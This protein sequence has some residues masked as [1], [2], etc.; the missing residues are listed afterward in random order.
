VPGHAPGQFAV[1]VRARGRE[2]LLAA[3]VMHQPVQVHEPDWNSR[4]CED[5]ALAAHTRRRVLDYCAD[6]DCLLFTAHFGFPHG[7]RIVRRGAGY[8]FVPADENVNA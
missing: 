5:P 8:G 4:Y 7:G 2:V 3:D 6:R 1:R